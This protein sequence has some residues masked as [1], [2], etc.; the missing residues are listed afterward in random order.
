MTDR[1]TD[2]HTYRETAIDTFKMNIREE[3]YFVKFYINVIV[4]LGWGQ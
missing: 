1:L 3:D 2:R 4:V